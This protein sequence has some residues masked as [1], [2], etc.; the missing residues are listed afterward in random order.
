MIRECSVL[1]VVGTGEFFQP[2]DNTF[3]SLQV[4]N[5]DQWRCLQL[6]QQLPD[7]VSVE[8]F[9]HRVQPAQPARCRLQHLEDFPLDGCIAD[10]LRLIDA[11]TPQDVA[12]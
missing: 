5:L 9:G 6:R 1:R 11:R 12:V 2:K 7:R 10:Q 8:R 4:C 3:E